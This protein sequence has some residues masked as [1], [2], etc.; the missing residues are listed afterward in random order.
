MNSKNALQ[1]LTL[2]ALLLPGCVVQD[3]QQNRDIQVF[4]STGSSWTGWQKNITVDNS[5]FVYL[6]EQRPTEGRPI[7]KSYQMDDSKKREFRDLILNADVYGLED[8]YSCV[9]D[10]P[11]DRPASSIRFVI[12]G[13][14]KIISIGPPAEMPEGLK[15]ILEEISFIERDS[16]T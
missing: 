13:E 10:C 14:E 15:N 12:D 1:V 16:L 9:Q 2:C 5:G 4:Y 8:S 6:V 7:N 3:E 11:T